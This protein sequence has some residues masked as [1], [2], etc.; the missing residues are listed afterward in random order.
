MGWKLASGPAA[1]S[2]LR[3]L[4]AAGVQWG[5]WGARAPV[6]LLAGFLSYLV[7]QELNRGWAASMPMT[8]GSTWREE[9]QSTGQVVMRNWSLPT[10]LKS[11]DK[12][13]VW[14]KHC[15]IYF[16]WKTSSLCLS[17]ASQHILIHPGTAPFLLKDAAVQIYS[18][19]FHLF[20]W[21]FSIAVKGTP[22][23]VLL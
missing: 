11:A 4:L 23:E 5:W 6:L 14:N 1:C 7:A 20:S 9:A 17:S 22:V 21:S 10:A 8:S 12:Q 15:H 2:L 19:V 18:C 13:C 16:S 3:A